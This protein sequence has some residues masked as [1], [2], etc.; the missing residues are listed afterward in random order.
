M[1]VLLQHSLRAYNHYNYFYKGAWIFKEKKRKRDNYEEY[2]KINI[3]AVRR[4]AIPSG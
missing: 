1:D 2:R 4:G 3:K